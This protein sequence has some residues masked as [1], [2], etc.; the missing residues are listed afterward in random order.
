M[1]EG[2]LILCDT[3]ILIEIYRNN[4]SIISE[5]G[6]IGELNVALSVI[7]A[8]E[9]L[10]GAMNRKEL[11]SIRKDLAKVS[12]LKIDSQVCEIF[13]QLMADYSLSH[14]LDVPDGLIAATAI[15]NDVELFTLNKKHFQFI[16]GLRLYS[17]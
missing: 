14:H 13:L 15:R 16:Q 1:E 9:L 17:L 2:R 4:A 10:Y 5:V 7:S 3:N 8:G 12:L 6:K 11:A